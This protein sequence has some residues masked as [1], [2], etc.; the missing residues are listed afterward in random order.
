MRVYLDEELFEAEDVDPVCIVQLI[1]HARHG[2]HRILLQPAFRDEDE[3][4]LSRNTWLRN[5]EARLQRR[6]ARLLETSASAASMSTPGTPAITVVADDQSDWGAGRLT[7]TDALRLLE[8]PLRVL[9]ENRDSDWHFLLALVDGAHRR[10]LR[11]ARAER[12]LEVENGGGIDD[13]AK[14]LRAFFS[15]NDRDVAWHVQRLR[16][17]VMFDRDADGEDPR[18]AS[19]ISDELAR[20][21]REHGAMGPWPFPHLQL[22]RRTIE[23]YLPLEALDGRGSSPSDIQRTRALRRLRDEHPAEAFGYHMKEGFVKDARTLEK[24]ERNE[25]RQRWRSAATEDARRAEIPDE[26]PHAWRTL[27]AEIV[28]DLLFGFGKDV[29]KTFEACDT[30]SHW[31]DWLAREFDRGPAQQ[32]SRAEIATQILELV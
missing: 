7:A 12:W 8:A 32:P 3:R 23:S 14:H 5:Q 6:L 22:G 25:R 19:R 2:R 27:P 9:V 10:A 20:L 4:R 26:L 28:A 31:D 13:L 18:H 16:T 24:R 17:W 11:E 1:G 21:C 29:A 30:E 15:S